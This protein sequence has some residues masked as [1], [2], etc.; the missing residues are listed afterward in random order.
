LPA[1]A[2]AKLKPK[3]QGDYCSLGLLM[4][5][6]NFTSGFKQFKRLELKPMTGRLF[7]QVQFVDQ[8]LITIG[9]CFA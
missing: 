8:F 4:S 2:D 5:V 6:L 3:I 9:F 1:A 7:A